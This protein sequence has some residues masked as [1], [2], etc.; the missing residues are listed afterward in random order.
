VNDARRLDVD[1]WQTA[2]SG[3]GRI[4][5]FDVPEMTLSWDF[6]CMPPYSRVV[7]Y[8]YRDTLSPFD[9]G[10]FERRQSYGLLLRGRI[11]VRPLDVNRKLFY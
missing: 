10:D 5:K 6:A 1:A 7:N 11:V 3:L 8:G 9:R 4:G 2:L